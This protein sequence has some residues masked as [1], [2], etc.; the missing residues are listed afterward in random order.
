MSQWFVH[1]IREMVLLAIL[2]T[3]SSKCWYDIVDRYTPIYEYFSSQFKR[4]PD[5]GLI[6]GSLVLWFMIAMNIILFIHSL[7]LIYSPHVHFRN[8]KTR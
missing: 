6:T 7:F 4:P 3:A 8:Q 2:L 1:L 5:K